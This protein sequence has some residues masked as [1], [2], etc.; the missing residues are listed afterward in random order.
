MPSTTEFAALEPALHPLLLR[1]LS[2]LQFPVPTPV[3]AMLVPL[4][5]SSTRDILARARTGS[6]KTLAYAIPVVQSILQRRDRGELGGTRALILVPTR[7]LAEQ[8][9]AQV[10]RLI[11]GL[12]LGQHTIRI[13]NAAGH[14]HARKKRKT[15]GG[16]DRTE[17]L[18]L[19]DRPEIVVSTPSR[20]LTH[21]RAETLQLEHLDQLI[22]DEADLI[23]SYGH[24]SEDIRSILTGPWNLPKV[25]Q[26]FLMSATMTGEVDE[27]KGILLKNPIILKLEED[28]DELA[29]LAQYC[30][31]CSEEDK[32]L[33][34]YV[35]L[36]LRLIK[37]KCLIFVNDT[38]R[39][40]RLKLF[41]EKFGIKSGV[42]NAELPFN[43]RYH[44][45]QEFN[46]GVFDYLIATDESGLEGN[47][48]D[49]NEV[50]EAASTLIS[51]Q[52]GDA[53][54]QASTS[55]QPSKKRKR[56]D[57]SAK[58]TSAPEYGVSRGVD[59]VDVACV[60]NFD[61]PFSSRSYT[62]RVGRTA[63][64]GR[65]GTALSFI[66]PRD[67]WG[68]KKQFDVSL[69]T[70]KRD[71]TVWARIEKAQRAR[72]CELK[73]Y[74]F[75]MKQVEGFRYR[76]EDGLRSVTKASVKEARIKEIKNE[77]LNSEKLK[78]HFEDNPRDLAFLRHDKP[79]HPS[80][81]QAH[82][83]H[84][85]NYL[86]P[87]IAAVGGAS[88]ADGTSDPSSTNGSKDASVSNVPF[89]KPNRGG[90]ARGGKAGRGGRERG[91]A[92]MKRR[93]DPL[94]GGAVS[95]GKSKK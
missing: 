50:P 80:R 44:A 35:I 15:G 82:L 14:D 11:D 64:A 43:S 4:A 74:K 37:G 21:L 84:V 81:V 34:I 22:I 63:R 76:M 46:H 92:G 95:F 25:Y 78:A 65:T 40:Y 53:E 10:A 20:A 5:L 86:M 79:L 13:V 6:G 52:P 23:L 31:R 1:A 17:R 58:S 48:R 69:E 7:E 66:V 85:P 90:K 41:L 32:F 56:K 9:K 18:Q 68:K 8:V 2:A 19:A 62:H 28:Q 54:P 27:L 77:V 36:K 24:S 12:G 70:A 47:D 33:L 3:Q 38:D 45:V 83:K 55:E 91:S 89:H 49:D 94:K 29:N 93:V 72:G 30:V 39:G 16:G 71:E 26:T 61:L 60:V 75:D 42:L 88:A 87:R 57:G 67:L 59:F 73:E 51:T